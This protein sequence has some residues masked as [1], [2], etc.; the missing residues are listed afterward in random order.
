MPA[1]ERCLAG[2][3]ASPGAVLWGTIPL[4]LHLPSPVQVA[5]L[6]MG[7]GDKPQGLGVSAAMEC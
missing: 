2:A 5:Q 3:S 6:T 1:H 7:L 4:T